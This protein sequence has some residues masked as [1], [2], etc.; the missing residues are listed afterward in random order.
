MVRLNY[1][2]INHE[3]R[4][5][6]DLSINEYCIFDLIHNLATNPKNSHMGWCYARKETLADYLD[7]GRA[8][9][10]RA[11]KKGLASEL[12]EKHPDQPALIKATSKW[13]EAVIIKDESHNDTSSLKTRYASSQ[14]DTQVRLKMRTNKDINNDIYNNTI[15]AKNSAKGNGL[16]SIGEVLNHRQLPLTGGNEITQEW[17]A[18]ALRF[19]KE[20]GLGGSPSRQ[21]FKHVKFAFKKRQQG[22]LAVALSYC[23]DAVR[24]ED[25]EKLFYWRYTNE[26][27]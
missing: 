5:R 3:A 17:Q 10:F 26:P 21:F 7:I 19:W 24:V 12:L 4:V 11:I 13:Y 6:L 9:V 20:L 2:T 14:N 25:M 15:E 1:T 27:I 16:S 22:R 8:T 18:E 23:K